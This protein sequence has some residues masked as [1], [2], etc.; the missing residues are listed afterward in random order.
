[1]NV[2]SDVVVI[3]NVGLDTNVYLPNDQVDLVHEG[4][5]TTNID[6][7]GQAG[8]Y[9]SL[10]YA[11]LGHRTAFIGAIG[12]DCHGAL[13]RATFERQ[14]IDTRGLFVDP[15]GTCRSVN[16]V[17]PDGQR[18][19]FYDGRDHLHITPDLELCRTLLR[20][21]R[22]AHVNIPNWARLLLPLARELGVFIACDVQ[23][24]P[25]DDDP[26]RRDFIAAADV[27]FCSATYHSS[28]E[29]LAALLRR[30]R[31]NGLVVMGL[32]SRGCAVADEHELRTFPA[33]DLGRPV[34][35]TNGAGDCLA[36]GFLDAFVF[37]G[38]SIPQAA[39]HGQIAARL[40]CQQRAPKALI[41][42][43]EL[44]HVV[45]ANCK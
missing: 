40:A 14:G 45:A 8:G 20:G 10:G 39:L 29:S 22:L 17:F 41:T 28:P 4:H 26:Y 5:F 30:Q 7:V 34:I 2:N 42:A 11:R 37:K 31:P 32:G 19:N 43:D 23:D 16:L 15:Q 33:V 9:A 25:R 44:A 18:R 12:D 3:G 6:C 1:M 38:A 35:D 36:V 13:I 27:L 21:A 24:I